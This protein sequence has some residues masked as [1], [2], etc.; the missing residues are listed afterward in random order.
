M[1]SQ[2]LKKLRELRILSKQK[3]E[4][5]EA[6]SKRHLAVNGIQQWVLTNVHIEHALEKQV[7]LCTQGKQTGGG[8]L[9]LSGQQV[10]SG[11]LVQGIRPW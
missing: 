5:G 7:H 9:Q 8:I 4:P 1:W 6:K 3:L 2:N 11:S 10:P